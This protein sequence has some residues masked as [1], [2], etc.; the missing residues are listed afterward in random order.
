MHSLYI[1]TEGLITL[2]ICLYIDMLNKAHLKMVISILDVP[3][4]RKNASPSDK[5]LWR[6][7]KNVSAAEKS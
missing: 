4:D 6:F 3:S 7:L 5:Q 2:L 1:V